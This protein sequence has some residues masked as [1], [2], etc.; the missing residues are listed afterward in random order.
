MAA[1]G[2]L[3]FLKEVGPWGVILFVILYI[4]MK[5]RIWIQFPRDK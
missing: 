4:L 5:T 3:M 1:D 2:L